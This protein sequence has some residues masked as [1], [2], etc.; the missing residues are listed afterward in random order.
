M[1]NEKKVFKAATAFVD[2]ITGIHYAPGQDI[3]PRTLKPAKDGDDRTDDLLR[4]GLIMDKDTRLNTSPTSDGTMIDRFEVRDGESIE[5]ARAR[6]GMEKIDATVD[7]SPAARSAQKAGKEG[8][9]PKVEAT[10]VEKAGKD[11][12]Q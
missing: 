1:A 9:P 2:A 3:D 6:A 8:K 4:S 12:G 5:D 10:D 11:D 7:T